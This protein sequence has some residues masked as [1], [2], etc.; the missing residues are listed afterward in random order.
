MSSDL[1]AL[2]PLLAWFE[3]LRHPAVPSPLWMQAQLG[4]VEGFTNAVRHAHA[5]LVPPPDVTISVQVAS[6]LFCVEVIDQGEPFDLELALAQLEEEMRDGDHDPLA[7]EAHWG[8]VMLLR[9]RK[10]YGWSITYHRRMEGGNGLTLRHSIDADE[11]A[12]RTY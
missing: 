8:L 9:L 3:Q 11:P 2:E 5:H 4:L 6:G 7:R 12:D 10:D 1:D